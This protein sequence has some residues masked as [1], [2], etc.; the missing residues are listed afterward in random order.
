MKIKAARAAIEAILASI[1]D[2][3]LPKFDRTEIDG[4]SGMP[5]VWW[6]GTGRHLGSAKRGGVR[7]PEIY[8]RDASWSAIEN[9]MAYRAD[10]RLFEA[11]DDPAGFR[12]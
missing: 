4:K 5:V 10:K 3:E 7:D 12:V 11:N 1:P 2:E 6:G 9:E 8:R